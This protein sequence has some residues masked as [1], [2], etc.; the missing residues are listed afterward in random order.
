MHLSWALFQ[1][2]EGRVGR[3][4]SR[5]SPAGDLREGVEHG[6]AGDGRLYRA[7]V[8]I[9]RKAEPVALPDTR[10]GVLQI[11]MH[12]LAEAKRQIGDK[13]AGGNHAAHGEA[14]DIAHCMLEQLDGRGP[15]PAPFKVSPSR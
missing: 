12:H 13:M 7:Y 4:I 10:L 8:R 1:I 15:G 11:V 5:S 14:G 6:T 9:W 2:G 3:V